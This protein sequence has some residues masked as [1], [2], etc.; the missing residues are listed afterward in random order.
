MSHNTDSEF[1]QWCS[2]N[3][4]QHIVASVRRPTTIGKVEAYHKAYAMEAHKFSSYNKWVNY[5]NN[6]RPHQGISYYYPSD[7]YFNKVSYH[8]G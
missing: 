7:L 4:I 6:K 3:D 5:W 1:T 2:A 8:P